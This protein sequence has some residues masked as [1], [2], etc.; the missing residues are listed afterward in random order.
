[1]RTE[2]LKRVPGIS[3]RARVTSWYVG[4]LAATLIVFSAGIYVGMRT[5]LRSSLE[6]S[7]ISNASSIGA[8]F[9]AF[10]P[11]KGESW[12]LGE[13]RESYPPGSTDR[14]IRISSG[15]RVL[16]QSW[17]DDGRTPLLDAIPIRQVQDQGFRS[18]S[19]RGIPV[20]VYGVPFRGQNGQEFEIEVAGSLLMIQQTLHSLA[21]LF[22]VSTPLILL[23]AA[24]GGYL[25]MRRPLR[26]LFVLTTKAESI[27][28]NQMGERLPILR[29]N[30]EL[31]RLTHSL[32]RMI[33]RLEHALDHNRRFS[34]DASHELRTPLTIM[35]GELEEVIEMPGLP[36]TAAENIA[37][38]LD[39]IDRMSSIVHSL[40][41]I[42]RLDAGGER[43]D[44]ELLNLT[45]L[46]R[47][48]IE[49][50]RLLAVERDVPLAM[51]AEDDVWVVADPLR[52]KQVLVNLV[53][54]A[55]KYT[56]DP[57]RGETQQ[58]RRNEGILVRVSATK[59]IAVVTVTDHGV[60][61]PTASLP[62]VFERFYRTDYARNRVGGGVGLGLAIVKSIV[63][64]HDGTVTIT[65]REGEGS[66][67]TVEL[68]KADVPS[69]KGS[70]R[71]TM[72]AVAG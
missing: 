45:A 67:V 9:L 52:T 24:A 71:G 15:D 6:Q 47:T 51:E 26:P 16:Y 10:L 64:A 42:T 31:E 39:E 8:N 69:T 48:T 68:P 29:T 72:S 2:P 13:I 18:M 20:L 62:H 14:L 54:N 50:M 28:R 1:M 19:V 56:L 49:H 63:A 58:G 23:A 22:L 44:V 36:A 37:S 55:I 17:A 38:T 66:T 27:G 59:S 60:G 35:R 57:E 61:I 7:L 65:S 34:A 46:A 4:L 11:E 70:P 21:M 32:N 33:D 25:M 41:A 43:M 12:F 40:M 53:D 3:L 5:Y 30:D